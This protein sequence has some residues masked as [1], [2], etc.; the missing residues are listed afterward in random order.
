M[1]RQLESLAKHSGQ[2]T[3]LTL[4]AHKLSACMHALQLHAWTW[5]HISSLLQ[6]GFPGQPQASSS[7]WENGC[8]KVWLISPIVLCWI[9]SCSFLNSYTL[10]VVH[11]DKVKNVSA[12]EVHLVWGYGER[13]GKLYK[14]RDLGLGHD[15][16]EYYTGGKYMSFD[17]VL[18][19]TPEGFSK[20]VIHDPYKNKRDVSTRDTAMGTWRSTA[21]SVIIA[22]AGCLQFL[23]GF[24]AAQPYA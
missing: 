12:Y 2:L 17:I 10:G 4:L 14:L 16:P 15:P 20:W 13:E 8:L 23:H 21:G 19:P 24:G 18:P 5:W 22:F 9:L 3:V 1:Q 11:L 7:K 6:F